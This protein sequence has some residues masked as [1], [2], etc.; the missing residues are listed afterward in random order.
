VF[1]FNNQIM[2]YSNSTYLA[3]FGTIVSITALIQSLF[4]GVGQAIQPV[5]SSNFG[6]KNL[7]RVRIV[8]RYSIITALVMGGLFFA[9]IF[10]FPETIL[11]MFMRP[12]GEILRVGPEIVRIYAFAYLLMGMNI[13]GSYYLQALKQS[14]NALI[15]SLLRGFFIYL[16]LVFLLPAMAGFNAIWLTMPVTELLT[17]FLTLKLLHKKGS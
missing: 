6:V 14:K 10:C 1:C 7:Y 3:V 4:Y 16:I 15:I 9:L 17:L 8:L 13:I 11:R 2:R 5:V 12:T